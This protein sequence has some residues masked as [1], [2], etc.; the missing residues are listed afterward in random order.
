MTLD[1]RDKSDLLGLISG[2]ADA[3]SQ[4]RARSL[5]NTSPDAAAFFHQI[6]FVADACRPSP[7]GQIE[8][9]LSPD[10]VDGV[11]V[12]VL[13]RVAARASRVNRAGRSVSGTRVLS[14]PAFGAIAAVFVMAVCVGWI[15]WTTMSAGHWRSFGSLV[16]V[17]QSAAGGIPRDYGAIRPGQVL[18][19]DVD[20]DARVT[21]PGGTTLILRGVTSV[22]MGQDGSSFV[23]RQGTVQ[24]GAQQ[25]LTIRVEDATLTL[26]R[27]ALR[28]RTAASGPVVELF[29]GHAMVSTACESFELA[30]GQ[31]ARWDKSSRRFKVSPLTYPA[32]SWVDELLKPRV[33]E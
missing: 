25:A 12:A 10:E 24:V 30:A 20:T 22:Q 15:A 14:L 26:P 5:I 18:S 27:G 4:E 3:G 7:A 2:F 19:P 21:L 32:P 28:V 23:Y 17:P 29:V 31:Q 1:E 6:S 8:Q 11:T 9:E 33:S 13:A 16:M